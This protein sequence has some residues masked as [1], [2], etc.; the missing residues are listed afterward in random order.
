[1]F[2]LASVLNNSLTA[3]APGSASYSSGQRTPMVFT[4]RLRLYEVKKTTA[5]PVI[6]G[7]DFAVARAAS[8]QREVEG[9]YDET[10]FP[11]TPS[12][13]ERRTVIRASVGEPNFPVEPAIAPGANSPVMKR[14]LLAVN[15]KSVQFQQPKRFTKKDT[16][17]GSVFFHFTNSQGQNNDILTMNFQG[18]TGNLDMRAYTNPDEVAV[19]SGARYK[20]LVWHNLYLLT[21]EP[22]LL[23]DNSENEFRISYQSP[24][25]SQ[26]VDFVGFFNTVLEFTESAEKPHSRDYSFGFTVKRT[27]PPLDDLLKYVSTAAT[28]NVSV[29]PVPTSATRLISNVLVPSP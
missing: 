29:E 15:P 20:F 5:K 6:S 23:P 18:N 10:I 22:M 8:L 7:A 9:P 11:N 17:N 2:D 19:D 4:S 13:L 12:Q 27:E 21:R 24:L 16:R 1:M 14:I 25:F 26:T 3:M 28:G